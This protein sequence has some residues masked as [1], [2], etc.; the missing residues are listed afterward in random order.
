M[1]CIVFRLYLPCEKLIGGG[2]RSEMESW[3]EQPCI[4]RSHNYSV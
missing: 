4:T 3:K 2:E 1:Q